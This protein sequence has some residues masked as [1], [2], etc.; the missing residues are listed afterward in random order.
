M[1]TRSNRLAEYPQSMFWIRKKKL[2]TP[3][4]PVSLHK[5]GVKEYNYITRT[6]FPDDALTR[7]FIRS[8]QV[9]TIFI[10]FLKPDQT[11]GKDGI[12]DVRC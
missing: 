11:S 9:D 8:G 6:C 7:H 12:K 4:N 3:Y 10:L 1:C 5:H 2:N